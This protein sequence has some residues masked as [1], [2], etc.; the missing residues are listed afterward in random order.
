MALN[1]KSHKK[2]IFFCLVVYLHA[3]PSLY[4]VNAF[5]SFYNAQLHSTV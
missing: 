3:H 5:A 1:D 4:E 2:S